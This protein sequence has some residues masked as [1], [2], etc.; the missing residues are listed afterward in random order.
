MTIQEQVEYWFDL[1]DEDL[2]V[3]ESNFKSEHYL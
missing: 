3:A 2:I 1:A